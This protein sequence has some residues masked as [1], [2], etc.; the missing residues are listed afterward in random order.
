MA[1][2]GGRTARTN[3]SM[4]NATRYVAARRETWRIAGQLPNTAVGGRRPRWREMTGTMHV[5]PA[6]T[7]VET[8]GRLV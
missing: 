4:K 1:E 3:N 5:L 7:T 8:P 6:T 2:S